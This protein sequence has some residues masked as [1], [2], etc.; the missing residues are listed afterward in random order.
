METKKVKI[1]VAVVIDNVGD[2][3]AAGWH[4]AKDSLQECFDVCFDGMAENE[5][6]EKWIVEA[7][8]DIPTRSLRTIE[9]TATKQ[10]KD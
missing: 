1:R 10:T 5:V 3:S 9:G 8:I 6:E 4:M 7:E 2:W